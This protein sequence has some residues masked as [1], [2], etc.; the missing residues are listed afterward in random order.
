ME[1]ARFDAKRCAQWPGIGLPTG[2]V[3][4]SEPSEGFRISKQGLVRSTDTA[5]LFRRI[6]ASP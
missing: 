2:R 6:A 3:Q 4:A 1:A 5:I